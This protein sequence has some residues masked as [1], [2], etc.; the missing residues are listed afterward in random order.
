MNRY[1]ISAIVLV[2]V[3]LLSCKD[4]GQYCRQG[5]FNEL[6]IAPIHVVLKIPS[7][8]I[9]DSVIYGNGRTLLNYRIRTIDSSLD[10]IVFVDDYKDYNDKERKIESVMRLQKQ[11][12]ESIL[13]S[14]ITLKIEEFKQIDSIKI[15]YVK[16][17]VEQ[18]KRKFYAGRIFFYRDKKLATIWLFENYVNGGNK[19]YS[20]ID[21]VLKSLKFQK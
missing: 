12:V 11:E 6:V 16:Y 17:L 1:I 2:N 15:G 18:K 14:A 21:C 13:E 3:L 8:K 7:Y 10:I 9:L 20:E 4:N 5:V 19:S